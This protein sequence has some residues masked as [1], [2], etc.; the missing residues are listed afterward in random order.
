M[1][2]MWTG[3]A[4]KMKSINDIIHFLG[5]KYRFNLLEK[6]NNVCVCTGWLVLAVV[7]VN[8]RKG[9]GISN[10]MELT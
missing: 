4:D 7:S 10:Q 1:F 3:K 9:G 5:V 6:E 8:F 2:I